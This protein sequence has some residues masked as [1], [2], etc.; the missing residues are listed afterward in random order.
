MIVGEPTELTFARRQKGI[1]NIQLNSVG[2]AV[3]SGYP[4]LGS[5]AIEPMVEVLRD[6]MHADWPKGTRSRQRTSALTQF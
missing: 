6:L 4:H 2:K 3:H 5:S 1:I